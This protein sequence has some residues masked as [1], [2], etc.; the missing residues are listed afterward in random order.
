[1]RRRTGQAASPGGTGR[2]A[3]RAVSPREARVSATARGHHRRRRPCSRPAS[4]EGHCRRNGPCGAVATIG[5]TSGEASVGGD[6]RTSGAVRPPASPCLTPMWA[7]SPAPDAAITTPHAKPRES[8]AGTHGERGRGCGRAYEP[9]RRTSRNAKSARRQRGVATGAALDG[10]RTAEPLL[11]RPAAPA[12]H[13]RPDEPA[14][15]R[16]PSV[17]EPDQ[18]VGLGDGFFDLAGLAGVAEPL[19]DANGWPG[20]VGVPVCG[21]LGA[22][23]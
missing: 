19:G 9:A 8:P 5:L 13:G 7:R 14:P 3:P 2:D 15:R 23:A 11:I 1:M 12:R 16:R 4:P 22:G 21:V 20:V 17:G 10:C 18:A 6:P